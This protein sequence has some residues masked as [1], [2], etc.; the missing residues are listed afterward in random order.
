M[1]GSWDSNFFVETARIFPMGPTKGSD[2]PRGPAKGV[3]NFLQRARCSN[4]CQPLPR[5]PADGAPSLQQNL[6]GRQGPRTSLKALPPEATRA[7]AKHRKQ[8]EHRLTTPRRTNTPV[9]L[10]KSTVPFFFSTFSFF[11]GG[12]GVR[13][14]LGGSTW[15]KKKKK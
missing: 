9:C 15:S 2:F 4:T 7:L 3:F 12:G 14:F 8:I 13:P 10:G 6:T 5:K 1:N 11:F